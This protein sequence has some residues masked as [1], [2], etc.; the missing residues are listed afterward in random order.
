MSLIEIIKKYV[1]IMF[2]PINKAFE[3]KISLTPELDISLGVLIVGF[4][5]F[6]LLV[7]YIMKALDKE[8]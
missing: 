6:A 3:I 4:I 7:K 8:D 2:I 1:D 5:T